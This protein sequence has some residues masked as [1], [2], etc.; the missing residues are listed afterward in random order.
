MRPYKPEPLPDVE[1]DVT[2][3]IDVVLLL[4]I[5]FMLTSQFAKTQREPMDLPREPGV[6]AHAD[7]S[8][9]LVIDLDRAGRLA[10]EGRSLALADLG[11]F[12]R[13]ETSRHKD[14]PAIVV[15]ADRSVA[16]ERLNEIATVLMALRVPDWRLA[17][18]GGDF[19]P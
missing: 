6:R 5:F 16:S 15:R 1:M 8:S 12:I 10:V 11:A 2:N 17:T 13:Q 3:L 4:I 14:R 19:G 7:H 18:S 9:E